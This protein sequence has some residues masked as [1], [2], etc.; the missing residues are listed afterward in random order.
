M[1]MFTKYLDYFRI[2]EQM[3][4]SGASL[5]VHRMIVVERLGFL[6]LKLLTALPR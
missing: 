4:E 3:A 1:G 6:A 2:F 5:N